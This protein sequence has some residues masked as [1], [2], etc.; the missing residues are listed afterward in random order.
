MKSGKKILLGLCGLALAAA[1]YGT[2][3]IHRG[4][5]TSEEPS[6]LEKAVARTARHLSIRSR[7]RNE[8]NPWKA[9]QQTLQEARDVYLARCAVGHGDDGSGQSKVGRNL[10]PKVPDLRLPRTQELSDGEIHAIIQ[11][12]VRLT[13]MPGWSKPHEVQDQD[14]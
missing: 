6:A 13:G 8:K 4:F 2:F 11:N 5:S 14:N 9:T 7:A 10:Y 3:L 12:G 1:V